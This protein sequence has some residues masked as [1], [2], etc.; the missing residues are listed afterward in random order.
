ME[1][2]AVDG[3]A[4]VRADP[5]PFHALDLGDEEASAAAAAIRAGHLVGNGVLSRRFQMAVAAAAGARH[6]AF[7]ASAT[8]AF[9]AG[10]LAAD[11]PPGDEVILPSFAFVSVAN[12]IAL[13]G[14]RPRFV[15]IEEETFNLD[16]DA[17]ARAATPRTRAV[18]PVHY[19]GQ[20]C[21]MEAL[22]ALARRHGFDVYEDAAQ[23]V[24]ASF[25]GRPLGAWGRFGV[26][27]F[28]ATKNV[29]TGEGGALLTSDD[30]LAARVEIVVEKGTNRSAF[31]R[32]EVDRYTWVDR[33]ASFVQSDLLAA[34]GLVQLAKV[35]R[36]TARRREIAG[37]YLAGLTG[38]PGVRP[39]VVRA[40]CETNWHIFAL[41]VP[42]ERRDFVLRALA[43]EGVG[44]SSH[45]VPLH[46]APFARRQ[47]GPPPDLPVTDRVAA[48]IVRLPIH[49]RLSDADARDVVAAVR[50][51]AAHL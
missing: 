41:R 39:P 36:L 5:I 38:L 3:G 17:V 19:G 34:V 42:P 6:A 51:V 4:P 48:S 22:T 21:D 15:D 31:L 35:P 45:F 23:A 1:K 32:G 14:L 50:K 29:S 40:G 26:Y 43:A 13:C 8:A 20:S 12:V 28:H 44:A 16:L 10:L 30:A 25:R 7:T 46:S 24:G 33:G 27:S 47:W 9:H 18:V 2:L 11:L 49:T 37:I